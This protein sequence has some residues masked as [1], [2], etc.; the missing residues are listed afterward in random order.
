MGNQMGTNANIFCGSILALS[1]ATSGCTMPISDIDTETRESEVDTLE[2][3][4]AGG[5]KT[6]TLRPEVGGQGCTFTLL[7]NSLFLTAAHCAHSRALYIAPPEKPEFI[8][9]IP[10]NGVPFVPEIERTYALSSINAWAHGSDLAIGRLKQPFNGVTPATM[11][12]VAPTTGAPVTLFGF[13]CSDPI[14]P[15]QPIKCYREGTYPTSGF[16]VPG[17]SG[18]PLFAGNLAAN[19]PVVS[20]MSGGQDVYSHLGHHSERLEALIRSISGGMEPDF[21]RP[22]FAFSTVWAPFGAVCA[23]LCDADAR[24]RSFSFHAASQTCRLKPALFPMVPAAGYQS[25][26]P[27]VFPGV[28]VDYPGNDIAF[29]SNSSA[30]ACRGLCAQRSDC[31][32][33][34]FLGGNCW[35]KNAASPA[36]T[37]SSCVSDVRRGFEN[38]WDRP[39]GDLGSLPVSDAKSCSAWCEL[40]SSCRAFTYVA[41]QGLCYLKGSVP[42]PVSSE[43]TFWMV[44]GVKRGLEVNTN[45]WGSDIHNFYITE[46][47]PQLCQASCLTQPGCS[48]WTMSFEPTG[49]PG[50]GRCWLKSGFPAQSWLDGAVSGT[51]GGGFF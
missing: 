3:A 50:A 16:S 40:A 36:V 43:A 26:V 24:C 48:S 22:G 49:S 2:Q 7:T 20:V 28:A 32:A 8:P 34:T 14:D 45:R 19:G 29:Q 27:G 46:A 38:R 51:N 18:G 10:P 11:R 25:G 37:C 44:S 12:M 41:T 47:I 17:D 35:L 13:G 31:A 23:K 42:P 4:I 1:L 5:I 9:F 21:D 6:K 39:G 30:D 15:S 33:Y